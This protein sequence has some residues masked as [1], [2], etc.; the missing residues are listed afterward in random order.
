MQLL[1]QCRAKVPSRCTCQFAAASFHGKIMSD[2]DSVAEMKHPTRLPLLHRTKLR[3]L[4]ILKVMLSMYR[5]G[6]PKICANPSCQVFQTDLN[7]L[8]ALQNHCGAQPIDFSPFSSLPLEQSGPGI[9]HYGRGRHSWCSAI[10]LWN[11]PK[12]KLQQVTWQHL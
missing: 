1:R 6:T 5:S 9:R 4:R 11:I 2:Y 10:C 8:R 3:Q 7:K 12:P